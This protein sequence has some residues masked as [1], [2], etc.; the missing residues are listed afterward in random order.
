MN[1]SFWQALERLGANG[2]ATC[3][4]R[5]FL[6]ADYDASESFLVQASGHAESVIDPA[7]PPRRLRIWPDDV[8]VLVPDWRTIATCLGQTLGFTPNRYETEGFTRQIGTAQ[9]GGNPIRPVILCL[10]AGH[11]GDS[12]RIQ[13]DLAARQD[14]TV[15]LP[16]ATWLTTQIQPLTTDNK[17][18]FNTLR[19]Y[20]ESDGKGAPVA[21]PV[22]P[23]RD[24]S[25]AP[26]NA[27]SHYLSFSP[28]GHGGMSRWK[29]LPLD[30]SSFAVGASRKN[31]GFRKGMAKSTP[32][33]MPS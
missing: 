25:Q 19:E 3:D 2:A 7:R 29:S 20:F 33:G 22:L 18:M 6:G 16:S 9:G 30:V 13:R 21:P 12:V 17:I 32:R 11:C 1:A 27:P 24:M 15:L 10:P 5:H 8:A 23:N 31:A 4:W 14:A 28:V 26:P